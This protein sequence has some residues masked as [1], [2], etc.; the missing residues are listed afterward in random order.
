MACFKTGQLVACCLLVTP[1]VT[2]ISMAAETS[3]ALE[4]AALTKAEEDFQTYCSSCHGAGGRGD[5][6]VAHEL[7][8]P[9]ADLTRIADRAGGS[10]PR[11]EVYRKIDGIDMP[12]AHGTSDMPVWGAWFVQQAIGEGVLIEDA[13]TAGRVASQRIWRLVEYLERIQK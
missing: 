11:K 2:G 13:K 10:F 9:P 4:N 6:P 8:T 5:G 1:L 12:Q 3:P 7:R